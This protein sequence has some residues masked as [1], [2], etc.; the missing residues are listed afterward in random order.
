MK[1]EDLDYLAGMDRP[2]LELNNDEL[3]KLNGNT[4]R[5][6]QELRNRNL[7]WTIFFTIVASMLGVFIG[8]V[9]NKTN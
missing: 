4:S 9:T 1:R 8:G 6:K 3:T 2:H 7:C 5:A